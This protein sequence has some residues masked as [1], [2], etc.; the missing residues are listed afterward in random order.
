MRIFLQ[1]AIQEQSSK[2]NA[3]LSV[4]ILSNSVWKR[5]PFSDSPGNEKSRVSKFPR[6]QSVVSLYNETVAND[7]QWYFKKGI[8]GIYGLL[9]LVYGDSVLL[10]KTI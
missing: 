1:S 5:R 7:K 8:K 4:C 9:Q 6:S 10:L 3:E 2:F